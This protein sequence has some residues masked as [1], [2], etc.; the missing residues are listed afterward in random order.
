MARQN[1]TLKILCIPTTTPGTYTVK[2][3]VQNTAG[4][5]TATKSSYIKV[6]NSVISPVA[7]FS[8]SPT[9]GTVPLTVTFT[10]TSTGSPSSWLWNFGDGSTSNFQSMSHT[11]TSAGNYTV[12][13]T[14]TNT[15]G[16]SV[17]SSTINVSAISAVI[18]DFNASITS[19]QAPLT[20][21]FLDL[22]TGNPTTWYW[23]FG[24]GN[25]STSQNPTYT[26]TEPGTYS[27]SLQASTAS[28][29]SVLTMPDYITVDGDSDS[30]SD[31]SSSSS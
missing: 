8:A 1:Y 4:S 3:T 27:V 17:S 25:N 20:V 10:D 14:A 15:A 9:S 18:A 24:D 23:D 11:Y 13:L 2:L 16:S 29:Q 28:G 26:Y 5:S 31:I 19:G 22:S 7:S 6:N 21:Q 30:I 12:T